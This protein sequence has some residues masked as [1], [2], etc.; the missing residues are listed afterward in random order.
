MYITASAGRGL[1]PGRNTLEAINQFTGDFYSALADHKCIIAKLHLHLC[2]VL[3]FILSKST[4]QADLDNINQ[5][6]HRWQ[7]QFNINKCKVLSVGRGDPRNTYYIR[8]KQRGPHTFGMWKQTN[9]QT[10]IYE[11]ELALTLLSLRTQCIETTNKANTI[12]TRT[13]LHQC[14]VREYCHILNMKYEMLGWN[15]YKS[16]SLSLSLSLS[17]CLSVCLGACCL[18]PTRELHRYIKIFSGSWASTGPQL[19]QQVT[20]HTL[21]DLGQK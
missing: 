17:V 12:H 19:K 21:D 5:W 2:V 7:M 11:L 13:L 4:L 18:H 3:S 9:K 8:H 1:G 16:L 6:T 10:N 20:K 14:H 15:S